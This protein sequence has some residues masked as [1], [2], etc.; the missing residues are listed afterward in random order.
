MLLSKGLHPVCVSP[1][2][3]LCNLSSPANTTHK[4]SGAISQNVAKSAGRRTH[5]H[6]LVCCVH[7]CNVQVQNAIRGC[8]AGFFRARG[9]SRAA[10]RDKEG[11]MWEMMFILPLPRSRFR[12]MS[13]YAQ[14]E[15]S[16]T[17]NLFVDESGTQLPDF[18]SP[19]IRDH[20]GKSLDVVL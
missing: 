15:K 13:Q 9:H 1:I 8:G 14:H 2:H 19:P 16:K 7:C 3:I 10:A 5:T 18:A 17:Q 4:S 12:Y 20:M 6:L 11:D